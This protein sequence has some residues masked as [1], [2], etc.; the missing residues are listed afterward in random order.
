MSTP[1]SSSR[2]PNFCIQIQIKKCCH[3]LAQN[4]HEFR[5]C[6][7]NTDLAALKRLNEDDTHKTHAKYCWYYVRVIPTSW[8]RGNFLWCRSQDWL[9]T[10]LTDDTL[11][12]NYALQFC[13][14]TFH[15]SSKATARTNNQAISLHCPVGGGY[16]S[17]GFHDFLHHYRLA[18]WSCQ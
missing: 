1:S 16:E 5:K 18:A 12:Y 15:T 17:D 9:L 11:W 10:A 4:W 13:R 14:H 2:F 8:R 3:S 7:C 6:N